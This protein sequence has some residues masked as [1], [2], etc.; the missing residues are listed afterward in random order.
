MND[1]KMPV[2]ISLI[3]I[4]TVSGCTGVDLP[5]EDVVEVDRSEALGVNDV[6]VIKDIKTMPSDVIMPNRKL[7]IYFTIANTHS[8]ETVRKVYSKLYD[9]FIFKNYDSQVICTTDGCVPGQPA[10]NEVEVVNGRTDCYVLP[11][12]ETPV[13]FNL[14][15]PTTEEIANIR[16]KA[17]LD[18]LVSYEFTTAFNYPILV[19]NENEIYNTQ[20]SG[21]TIKKELTTSSSGGPVQIYAE[22]LGREFMLEG[23]DSTIRFKITEVGSKGDLKKST[24][25]EGNFRVFFPKELFGVGESYIETPDLSHFNMNNCGD[26]E[27][28]N[29]TQDSRGITLSNTNGIDLHDGESSPLIFVIFNAGGSGGFMA[30]HMIKADA[31][32]TYEV[33]DKVEITIVPV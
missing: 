33:K 19:V 22:M 10:C 27:L 14:L 1:V 16:T 24:I 29:C 30:T 7:L 21:G 4:I 18:F 28:F 15:S 11:L 25:D 8:T 32:Y 31:T 20:K 3:A 26:G 6:I 2:I 12:G 17:E 23:S 9:P 5:F 13:S